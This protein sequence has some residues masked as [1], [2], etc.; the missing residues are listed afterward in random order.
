MS[1]S[2]CC[3]AKPFDEHLCS[4]HAR[5][6][7]QLKRDSVTHGVHLRSRH[8]LWSLTV[9]GDRDTGICCSDVMEPV[10]GAEGMVQCHRQGSRAGTEAWSCRG[11]SASRCA[12]AR[13]GRPEKVV[14]TERPSGAPWGLCRPGAAAGRTTTGWL[15]ARHE[16]TVFTSGV[17]GDAVMSAAHGDPYRRRSDLQL[18]A[19]RGLSDWDLQCWPR[20]CHHCGEQDAAGRV[21]N[22]RR[23][24]G[25]GSHGLDSPQWT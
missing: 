24:R 15:R 4:S 6:C 14:R 9:F 20:R 12:E 18:S 19:L 21:P 10:T 13:S 7:D 5:P 22:P 2:L 17:W 25:G 16:L 3:G 1:D 11:P 23:D 8:H